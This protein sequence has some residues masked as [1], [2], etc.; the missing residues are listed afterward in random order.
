MYFYFLPTSIFKIL[1]TLIFLIHLLQDYI[2]KYFDSVGNCAK[3]RLYVSTIMICQPISC[4]TKFEW[5]IFF[6][7]IKKNETVQKLL[8]PKNFMCNR[9]PARHTRIVEYEIVYF[10]KAVKYDE[11]RSNNASNNAYMVCLKRSYRDITRY[12]H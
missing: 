10:P 7:M 6:H 4:Y 9:K 12:L 3:F 5:P 11:S 1:T 8:P 2:F